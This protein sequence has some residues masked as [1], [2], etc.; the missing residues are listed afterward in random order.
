[1]SAGR[2][3]VAGTAWLAPTVWAGVADG[4]G[5]RFRRPFLDC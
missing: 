3:W 5:F 1:M 2:Y 4:F